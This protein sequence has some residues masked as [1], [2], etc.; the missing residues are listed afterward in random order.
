[1]LRPTTL[2]TAP[3]IALSLPF[4][5]AC[6]G[7]GGSTPIA[8]A[9]VPP[10][11]LL[12]RARVDS[13]HSF[14]EI[15]LRSRQNLG[16]TRI[17]DRAGRELR[18][19]LHPDGNQIVFARERDPGD[20]QSRELFTA[21]RDG[22]KPEQRLTVNG[23]RDDEPCWSLDGS[24]ILFTSEA[25][26][27]ARLWRTNAA[28]GGAAE[29]LLPPAGSSDGEPDQSRATGRIVFVR[30]DATGRHHLRLVQGDGTG[31]VAF[32]DGGPAAGPETGDRGPA[33][34]ADGARIAFVRYGAAGRSALC[35]A[36]VATGAVTVRYVPDGE[37]ALPR[38][39]PAG[40]F[41]L[42]GLAEPALGRGTLR[43][44]SLPSA[45][46]EPILH[47]PD[48]RWRLEGIDVLPSFAAPPA[49]A[50]PRTL[51]VTRTE[52][53]LASG[54]PVSGSKQQLV[55]AD[56][57]ELVVAT[58]TFDRRELAGINCR[59]D[60]PVVRA[61]D[62]LEL[63]VRAIARVGRSD[64]D[65]VLRMSIYNPVDE[66]F[67]TVVE[68]APGGTAARTLAF[69]TNSLRHVTRERQL[70]VTVIGDVAPGT[71]TELAVDLVEVV[72]VAGTSP[73]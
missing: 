7:G 65:S 37:A 10:E 8:G 57:D 1:M 48:E 9:D 13:P 17:A 43:L 29:F 30:R 32:T 21:A 25:A 33:F 5:A 45:G 14:A 54:A 11:L 52:V 53:Q 56:G 60:L 49:A 15:A 73:P 51:D 4:L 67:D 64:G 16:G 66:R 23:Q 62:T 41:V 2:R 18:A 40:D 61:D 12:C 38:F 42:F 39:S 72:L 24:Q 68:L 63:H 50:A 69:A 28:G 19:R 59:F 6:S 31:E 20:P 70:R 71:R 34:S 3:A 47:W 36:E 35:I 44:A 26:G 46:G 27:S 55:A 22:S 58:V